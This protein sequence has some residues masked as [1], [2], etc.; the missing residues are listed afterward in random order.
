[1]PHDKKIS[2]SQIFA[3]RVASDRE[4]A[5]QP[6][7][8]NGK[9]VV[10][11]FRGRKSRWRS[12]NFQA[13]YFV[14]LYLGLVLHHTIGTWWQCTDASSNPTFKQFFGGGS[15][16]N[17]CRG[18]AACKAKLEPLKQHEAVFLD[19]GAETEWNWSLLVLVIHSPCLILCSQHSTIH[20]RACG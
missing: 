5:K 8:D 10:C 17:H 7:S 11:R 16:R 1:M 15:S 14:P 18:S 13:P 12:G 4:R 9:K 19:Q 20:G 2:K 3:E 6:C